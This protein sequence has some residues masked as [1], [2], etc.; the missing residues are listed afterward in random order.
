[1]LPKPFKQTVLYNHMLIPEDHRRTS[2]EMNM[3][4]WNDLMRINSSYPKE[5]IL[6]EHV[7]RDLGRG[8]YSID[9]RLICSSQE[10]QNKL[11]EAYERHMYWPRFKKPDTLNESDFLEHG[12]IWKKKQLG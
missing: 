11:D 10:V 7:L 1:M 8:Q 9:M 5:E 4:I 3:D 2:Q 6:I 12:T